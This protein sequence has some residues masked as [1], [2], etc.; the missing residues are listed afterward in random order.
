MIC[1]SDSEYYQPVFFEEKESI[2]VSNYAIRRIQ[3]K[4]TL[5]FILNIH[6]AK[7][8]PSISYAFGLFQ[9]KVLVGIVSYGMPA[10]A[11]LCEGIAGK[12][13]KKYV[14]ELNRLVLKNNKKNEASMLIAASFKLLP[15]P[16]IIVSYA[17]TKQ[18][19]LGIVYQATN[20]MFTGTTKE[21]TDIAGEQGK[22][23]RH[24]LGDKTKRVLR[25]AKHRYIYVIGNKKDKRQLKNAIN[26]KVKNYP[27]YNIPICTNI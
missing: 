17:D 27:K 15:K 10:S 3:H 11:S 5:P 16:K 12:N 14:L 20:F 19:H 1:H 4:E 18:Q 6:Y 22:H 25:S 24:H 9:N 23:S 26:Y 8:I 7:R 21:R 13:N 2:Y